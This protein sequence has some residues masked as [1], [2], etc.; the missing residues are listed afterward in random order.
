MS[1]RRSLL[2]VTEKGGFTSSSIRFQ[3]IVRVLVTFL[4]LYLALAAAH[5]NVIIKVAT[6]TSPPQTFFSTQMPQLPVNTDGTAVNYELGMRFKAIEAGQIKAIRFYKSPSETGIHT[7]KIYSASGQLLA[8][9]TFANETASGWQMQ[10][11]AAPLAIAANT[12]Y[13]VSVN[14]GNTFYVATN[15]GLAT[16]MTNGS[17]QNIV[18]GVYGPVGS[19]PTQVWE[20]SNYFRD[21]L[22]V[23]AS[24]GNVIRNDISRATFGTGIAFNSSQLRWTMDN[25]NAEGQPPVTSLTA[26]TM[27]W[28][29]LGTLRFPNGD[30]SFLYFSEAPTMSYPH[31]EKPSQWDRYLSSD[32]IYR[33]TAADKLNMERLFE[34]NTVWWLNDTWTKTYYLNEEWND[35]DPTVRPPV[36]NRSHMASAANRAAQWV[37]RDAGRTQLWEVGNEDW[38][39]WN[40]TDHAEIF[41]AFQDAMKRANPNIKLLAQGLADNF[42][43]NT[44]EEWLAKLKGKLE[45]NNKVNSVYAY[46]VHKYMQGGVYPEDAAQPTVRRAK[47]TQDM[48]AAVASGEPV[49]NVKRLLGTGAPTSSTRDWKIWITEFNVHQPDGGK[50]AKGDATF[51]VPQDM[52][53]ALVIADWTGKMLEQNVERMMFHSLD[54]NPEFAL[55]QYQNEGSSIDHPYVTV[56]G[57]AYS[58]YAQEFGK[59]M[60]RTILT[61]NPM[62]KTPDGTKDYA[63]VSAYSSISEDGKSLRMMVINRHMTDRVLVN[64]NTEQAPGKRW[65]AAG[66]FAFRKLHSGKIDNS[67]KMSKDLVKW[68]GPNY[69]NSAVTG[70]E[71]ITLE[72]ASVNLFIIPLQPVAK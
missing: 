32:E 54:N 56:P 17:L 59:T 10:N 45:A 52:G 13:T 31:I 41:Y 37:T 27:K 16:Q 11:L 57:Y 72:P 43:I 34:V 61:Q 40:A 5:A 25:L 64:I 26:D 15:S 20:N 39:R 18:G 2:P 8:S 42:W 36:L 58:M 23:P 69:Y 14:T 24:S 44:P 6:T 71:N 29:D 60:V 63:Q 68:D 21:V 48:L 22:F 7:G 12:E 38:A 70:I 35:T 62:L 55:V 3:K 4:S 19:R 28:L 51:L 49:N 47:Q 46:S 66:K 33:Y 9:V 30:S 65:F 50:T 53:H 1:V 67:N